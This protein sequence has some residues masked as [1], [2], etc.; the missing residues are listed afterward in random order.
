MALSSN[1]IQT[2]VTV[3]PQEHTVSLAPVENTISIQNDVTSVTSVSNPTFVQALST[4]VEVVTVGVQGPPGSGG[5]SAEYNFRE[6]DAISTPNTYYKGW[7][8]SASTATAT[9][10]IL[11]GVDNL[12]GTFTET[13]AD[14]DVNLNNVWDDRLGLTY[15]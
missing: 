12:D 11:K 8:D 10:K 3:V 13:Y 6:Y 15:V 1:A 7:A 14:G 4:K 5:G 2:S 9:W